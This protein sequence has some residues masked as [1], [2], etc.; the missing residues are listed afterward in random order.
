VENTARRDREILEWTAI[1]STQAE[2][3]LGAVQRK[4]AEEGVALRR[5]EQFY[6]GYCAGLI[7]WNE[8]DH[9][10][11]PTGTS[12]GGQF[13]PKG[14]GGD[15]GL[16][17]AVIRRNQMVGKLTGVVTPEMVRSSQL[18]LKLQSAAQL[19]GEVTAAAAAGL[20]VGGKAVV[21]GSATA[22]KNQGDCTLK[23]CVQSIFR[24]SSKN[25]FC[26]SC[27]NFEKRAA[28]TIASEP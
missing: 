14:A 16:L 3:K 6:E 10:R 24:H 21:N 19:P 25:A 11:Q 15:G 5:A 28:S 27:K 18:A 4:E 7:E 2:E 12:A 23:R 26:A 20:K 1:I 9:P 17:G 8:A 22:V 13:A